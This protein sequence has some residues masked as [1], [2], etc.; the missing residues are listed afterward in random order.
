MKAI[1][2][3]EGDWFP[4]VAE[5]NRATG[6]S[7]TLLY[8]ACKGLTPSAGGLAWR[9]STG[10]RVWDFT[11]PGRGRPKRPVMRDDGLWFESSREAA[12]VVGVPCT[13]I[14]Q[15]CQ[16]MQNRS[17]GYGWR[18]AVATDCE[19]IDNIPYWKPR[20]RP[21]YPVMRS[22]G[23]WF[24]S[25]TEAARVTGIFPSGVSNACNGLSKSAGGY[26]WEFAIY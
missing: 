18:Y 8:Y 11:P 9:Y 23:L 17:A 13:C 7:S 26:G 21:T 22:D 25:M 6:T 20:G 1:T 4:S 24:S 3:N 14:A 2:S 19:P 10:P 5:A 15:V 16:G 12:R